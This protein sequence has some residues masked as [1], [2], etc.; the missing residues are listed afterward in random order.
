MF[1]RKAAFE[2]RFESKKLFVVPWS[3]VL[4]LMRD[5]WEGASLAGDSEQV[6]GETDSDTEEGDET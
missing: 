4:L 6:D 5:Q 2:I 1:V 3:A